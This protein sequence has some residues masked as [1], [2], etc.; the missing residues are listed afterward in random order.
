MTVALE[1][2]STSESLSSAPDKR[3]HLP[4]WKE[5]GSQAY[6]DWF[7]KDVQE[8]PTVSYIW[9]ADQFGHVGLGFQF[10]FL[11]AGIALLLNYSGSYL[12]AIAAVV[13]VCIWTLKE[14]RDYF[15]EHENAK[16][17]AGPFPFNAKEII[18][19]VLTALFY[20]FVG[21]AVAAAISFSVMW[22]LCI[23]AGLLVP[24]ALIGKW[25]L[26][27]KIVFQQAGLPYLYRLANFPKQENHKNQKDQ[28]DQEG[29]P[30]AF[31]ESMCDPK[32]KGPLHLI[33]GGEPDTGKTSLAVGIG[34]EFAFRCGIGRYIT[35]E[36]ML[37]LI[38]HDSE[39]EFKDGRILWPWDDSELLIIDD[40]ATAF[41]DP[42]SIL[43]QGRDEPPDLSSVRTFFQKLPLPSTLRQRRTVWLVEEKDDVE[44]WK[45]IIRTV[46]E[47]EKS[48][49]KTVWL[50]T[51]TLHL[52]SLRKTRI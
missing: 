28:K 5:V 31:I 21:A 11:F 44:T 15:R 16:A 35:F 1:K 6:R 22:S 51:D 4:T 38:R 9:T 49:L 34:T 50:K 2:L 48:Q 47:L 12:L 24:G 13:N 25:W 45:Q 26:S 10:T 20:I 39:K 37:E 8:T 30:K 42:G 3:P 32:K 18:K 27:R 7:G 33:I 36:K 17:A 41:R 40:V 52:R 19:N 46:L 14:I 29:F 43:F 23:L